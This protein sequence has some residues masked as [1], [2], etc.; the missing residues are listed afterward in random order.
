MTTNNTL[1]TAPRTLNN[2][3]T[4]PMIQGRFPRGTSA[5]TIIAFACANVPEHVKGLVPALWAQ[6]LPALAAALDDLDHAM[7]ITWFM[8]DDDNRNLFRNYRNNQADL[9]LR[10]EFLLA[11]KRLAPQVAILRKAQAA[12]WELRGLGGSF[13]YGY[14]LRNPYRV[15]NLYYADDD[16]A[17]RSDE[18]GVWDD[19]LNWALQELQVL[20]SRMSNRSEDAD[21]FLNYWDT[22]VLTMV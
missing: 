17:W 21:S 13:Q 7:T 6:H 15:T 16:S 20:D 8:H 12:L 18:N 11:V 4:V 10:A 22:S 3:K 2:G 5:A 14:F 19:A 9:G 1:H